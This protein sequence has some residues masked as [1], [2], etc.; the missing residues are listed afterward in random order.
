MITTARLRLRSWTQNDRALFAKLNADPYVM[1]Y[2]PS[3]LNRKESDFLAQRI[4]QEL[5]ERGWGLWAVE[6]PQKAS[7]IGF[8]GLNPVSFHAP[9]TPAVEIGW[10]LDAPYWNQGYATEGARA[11]LQYGFE[12]LQLDKIVSFTAL[13][14]LPS[15]RVM[16]KIGMHHDPKDDFDHPKVPKNCPLLHHVLYTLE[17]SEWRAHE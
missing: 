15:R 1:R 16:E 4:S 12:I 9:F 17:R 6:I 14:N 13:S 5:E 10:R 2:F 7:F 3:P 11:V 8:L